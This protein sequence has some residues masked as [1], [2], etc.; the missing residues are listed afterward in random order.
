M[1]FLYFDL[2]KNVDKK[3]GDTIERVESFLKLLSKE[4]ICKAD[5]IKSKKE[6]CNIL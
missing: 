2:D 6:R 1:K 3:T 5:G 4:E